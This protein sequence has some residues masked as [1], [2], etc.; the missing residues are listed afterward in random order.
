MGYLFGFF[1][2]LPDVAICIF[3]NDFFQAGQMSKKKVSFVNLYKQL[4]TLH[5][6]ISK[7]STRYST[8]LRRANKV[9]GDRRMDKV[10][11]M[12]VYNKNVSS[13]Y[14]IICNVLFVRSGF[15]TLFLST[16]FLAKT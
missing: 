7:E 9:G 10:I 3:I 1:I 11:L 2:N 15:F 13:Y 12:P 16:T 6:A 14:S 5:T 8:L 4:E